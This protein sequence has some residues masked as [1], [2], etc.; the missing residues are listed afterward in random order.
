MTSSSDPFARLPLIV[1]DKAVVFPCLEIMGL[2]VRSKA[3][4]ADGYI[5]FHDAFVRR[6]GDRLTYYQLSDSTR[7][8]R[9]QAKD[10][11]KV[12]GWF[13][14]SRSLREP[15]LGIGMHTAALPDEPWPPLLDMF[16]DQAWPQH[17]QAM[18]RIALPVDCVSSTVTEVLELVDDAMAEFP[19][20]WGTAGYAFYWKDTDTDIEAYAE[21]WLGGHLARHPGLAT[22]DCL[23]W[24][25]FVEHGVANVGWITFIGDAFIGQLGGRDALATAVAGTGITL[26][27]YDR[28]VGLQAGPQPELGDVNRRATLPICREV[29]RILHPVF[30]SDDALEQ[31]PVTGIQ[32]PD[33]RLAW[34]KRFLP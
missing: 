21:R 17:P 30:A 25:S 4:G 34:L 22:G 12:P 19:V 29:G 2:A 5:R 15:L 11:F 31:I 33:R 16:F 32:D 8:R 9:F 20:H 14:D 7:W 10:R 3:D 23:T 6:F 18:C 24:G 28:G 27:W 26:R 1:D 13:S